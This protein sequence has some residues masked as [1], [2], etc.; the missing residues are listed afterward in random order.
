MVNGIFVFKNYKEMY[1]ATIDF[2]S[3]SLQSTSIN[4]ES[5]FGLHRRKAKCLGEVEKS[6]ARIVSL[7]DE[8]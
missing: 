1:C 2:K 4:I 8:S 7:Q 5:L 6:P 3:A